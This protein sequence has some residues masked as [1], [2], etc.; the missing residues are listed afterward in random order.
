[1]DKPADKA[2]DGLAA[3]LA[4]R[5]AALVALDEEYVAKTIPQA[6]QRMRLM[7]L[8]KSRYEC[9]DI[10]PELRHASRAWLAENGCSRMTQGPLLPEGELPE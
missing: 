2:D 6:P 9:T 5:N 4:A 8:H 1:M 3:F 7:I 10:A